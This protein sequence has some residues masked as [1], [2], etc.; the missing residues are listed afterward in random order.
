MSVPIQL[1]GGSLF[2]VYSEAYQS[3]R[4]SKSNKTGLVLDPC[5]GKAAVSEPE[6]RKSC[7]SARLHSWNTMILK[8]RKHHTIMVFWITSSIIVGRNYKDNSVFVY[9]WPF[10]SFSVFLSIHNFNLVFRAGARADNAVYMPPNMAME[11]YGLA[12]DMCYTVG[13]GLWD[14]CVCAL[15]VLVCFLFGVFTSQDKSILFCKK[16]AC[17][18]VFVISAKSMERRPQGR[19][20][21][22][23]SVLQ[24]WR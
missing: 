10:L 17:W 1:F 7:R 13:I 4:M 2:C 20:S 12:Q 8:N 11:V 3:L 15:C 23:N 19:N 6:G 14:L 21:R 9:L 24:I 18:N 16:C 5:G 22:H